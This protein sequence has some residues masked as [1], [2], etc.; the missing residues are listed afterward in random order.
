MVRKF[1]IFLLIFLALRLSPAT[2]ADDLSSSSS[3][4]ERDGYLYSKPQPLDFARNTPGDLKEFGKKTFQKK[5]IPLILML[6]A[7]TGLL[8]L[9]DQH[10]VNHAHEIGNDLSISR[11][12]YQK[13]LVNIPVGK[14]KLGIEGPFDSGSALYYIG[15]GWISI[16]LAGGLL[17][18]GA[19]NSD[20]RALQTSSQI[21]E[22]VLASG[23]VAQG[24]KHVT[25]RGSPFTTSASGGTWHFF[26]NQKD[27]A[28]HVSSYDAFPSGHLTSSMATLTVVASNYSDYPWIRPVG[29]TLFA[30]LGF[31]MLNNGVHWASDYP[32][33]LALGYGFG[34]IAVAG[35]RKKVEGNSTISFSPILLPKGAGV[36][37]VYRFGGPKHHHA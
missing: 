18:Y 26:P 33:A 3:E 13:N 28:G 12:N 17:T 2:W 29:Y 4:Q 30:L 7:G 34:K 16:F 19:M 5:N 1:S 11:T 14:A 32:L 25:G 20:N 15:D 35:G 9:A 22:A 24:F 27:Y 10:L 36:Q 8:M 6:V 23:I 21:A 31:Q 37:T